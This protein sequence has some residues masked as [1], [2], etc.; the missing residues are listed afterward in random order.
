MTGITF[1]ASDIGAVRVA[2]ASRDR[3]GPDGAVYLGGVR[4]EFDNA[5]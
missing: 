1:A 5:G 4:L 3:A 2:A